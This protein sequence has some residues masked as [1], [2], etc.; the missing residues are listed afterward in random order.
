VASRRFNHLERSI[1][2]VLPHVEKKE[3]D[4]ARIDDPNDIGAIVRAAVKEALAGEPQPRRT[5][6]AGEMLAAV[7]GIFT[8]ENRERHS[9]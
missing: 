5:S 8:A 3:G 4:A 6:I 2:G 1:S 7:G 9:V